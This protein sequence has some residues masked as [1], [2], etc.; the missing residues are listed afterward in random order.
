M[1][2]LKA[3][4]PCAIIHTLVP[5]T[6]LQRL[7]SL[8]PRACQAPNPLGIASVNPCMQCAEDGTILAKAWGNGLSADAIA[9]NAPDED[10]TDG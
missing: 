10:M 8:V 6:V 5:V 3:N 2:T 7:S 1:S 4:T 9:E